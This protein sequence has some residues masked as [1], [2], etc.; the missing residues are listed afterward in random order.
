MDSNGCR[1]VAALALVGSVAAFWLNYWLRVCLE[2][3]QVLFMST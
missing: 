1:R 3:T 2:A